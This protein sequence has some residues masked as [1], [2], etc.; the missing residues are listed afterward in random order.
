MPRYN[1]KTQFEYYN[2]NV[3]NLTYETWRNDLLFV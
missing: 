1:K 2:D 3:E